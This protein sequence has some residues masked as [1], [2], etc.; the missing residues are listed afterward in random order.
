MACNEARLYP[1]TTGRVTQDQ[2]TEILG[3]SF[4]AGKAA[5]L[6]DPALEHLG[7]DETAGVAHWCDNGES[8]IDLMPTLNRDTLW[9]AIEEI[10]G[11]KRLSFEQM[12]YQNNREHALRLIN[13]V[14]RS[15]FPVPFTAIVFIGEKG[16]GAENGK[17]AGAS[18]GAMDFSSLD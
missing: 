4:L 11:R 6:L 5:E 10:A 18:P 3:G 12:G 15:A 8:T 2:R 9:N 17:P 1:V 16:S 7:T 13:D 14:A